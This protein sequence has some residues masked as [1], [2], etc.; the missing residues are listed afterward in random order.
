MWTGFRLTDITDM[1]DMTDKSMP[2]RDAI[3]DGAFAVL[4]EH[5]LQMVSY[6]RIAHASGLS[7]QVVRYHFPDSED[8]MVAV[9]DR[10]ADA[11]SQAL[12]ATAAA[13][14]GPSRIEVFLDFYF[15]LLADQPKPKDDAVYDAMM[16]LATGSERIQ[17]TLRTQYSLL[18]HI[19]THEFL[20]AYPELEQEAA[21]EL[22]YLFVALMYGH[23]KMVAT[24][25]L[26]PS[27]NQVARQGMERLIRCYVATGKPASDA[28]KIWTQS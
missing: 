2:P 14:N 4:L 8:L 13:L 26:S 27:H 1:T 5:G 10:M 24:L 12:V 7:R 21:A 19:L 6:D 18:G 25:G 11:Y 17:T 3:V 20:V 9:C 16:S 28:R 22:S 15:D 23:W